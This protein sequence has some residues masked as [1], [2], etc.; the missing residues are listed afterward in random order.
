M[1]PEGKGTGIGRSFDTWASGAA[2]DHIDAW[3]YSESRS[4][5]GIAGL[6]Y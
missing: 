5:A 3:Q 4:V 6:G 1:A 2:S